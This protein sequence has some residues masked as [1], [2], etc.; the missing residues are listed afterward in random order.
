MNRSKEISR[1]GS[2]ISSM[3][4]I[5]S[6]KFWIYIVQVEQMNK[7]VERTR[8]KTTHCKSRASFLLNAPTKNIQSG[9]GTSLIDIF[10]NI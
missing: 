4:C 10:E 6:I 2:D 1:R 3:F 9:R 7:L 5:S 8:L